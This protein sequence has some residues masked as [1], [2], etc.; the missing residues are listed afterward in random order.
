M[1]ESQTP[2]QSSSSDDKQ[3]H[4]RSKSSMPLAIGAI[5]LIILLC[6]AQVA[7]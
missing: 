2:Q 6:I 1:S 5:G 3:A 7:C 4:G